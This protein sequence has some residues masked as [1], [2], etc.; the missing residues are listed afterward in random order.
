MVMQGMRVWGTW[1]A[2]GFK[3]GVGVNGGDRYK[4]LFG[5]VAPEVHLVGTP[6]VCRELRSRWCFRGSDNFFKN[7]SLS[8]IKPHCRA[9][10][11]LG[12]LHHFL[13]IMSY[14]DMPLTCAHV[15]SL[16]IA[17]SH[18]CQCDGF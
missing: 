5:S 13:R 15:T 14:D 3:P 17:W 16:R 7:V 10:A 9:N 1:R 11:K 12:Q 8:K 4:L 18:L 6:S 2:A